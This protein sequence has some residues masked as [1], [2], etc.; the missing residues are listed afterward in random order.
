M[1]GVEKSHIIPFMLLL[2]DG[3]LLK[4]RNKLCH[5]FSKV[6]NSQKK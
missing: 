2:L 4:I 3:V 1:G 5:K 6:N